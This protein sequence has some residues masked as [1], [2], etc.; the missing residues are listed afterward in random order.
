MKVRKGKTHVVCGPLFVQFF[1]L[2]GAFPLHLSIEVLLEML[3]LMQ[4]RCDNDHD[5]F[6]PENNSVFN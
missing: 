3:A 2:A 4:K 1:V 6:Y 5:H